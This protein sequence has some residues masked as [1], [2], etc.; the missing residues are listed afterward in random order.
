MKTPSLRSA[1]AQVGK[2]AVYGRISRMISALAIRI[3]GRDCGDKN[4]TCT[5][6]MTDPACK[7]SLIE[8]ITQFYEDLGSQPS[9]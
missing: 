5:Y 2:S 7:K 9:Q 3:V 4:A 6:I 1:A 8:A